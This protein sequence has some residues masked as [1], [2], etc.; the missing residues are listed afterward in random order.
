MS[1]S[2]NNKE[3]TMENLDTR[4][5]QYLAGVKKTIEECG[6]MGTMPSPKTPA[7]INV[8][9]GSAEELSGMLK[10]L[11]GLAGV[12][13]V[14][15]EHMPMDNPE[16]PTKV[17]SAPPMK[18]EPSHGDDMKR[19]LSMMDTEHDIEEDSMNP[20]NE[21]V[22]DNSPEEEGKAKGN[23]AN[24]EGDVDNNF[25][26]AL[27]GKDK[28]HK[29]A[30]ES[31]F[32]EYKEFVAESK[33]SKG[34]KCNECGNWMSECSCD[35]V[36][37]SKKSKC[38]CKEK[39]K[40]KCP[41]HGKM[42][43][44]LLPQQRAIQAELDKKYGGGVVRTGTGRA[45]KQGRIGAKIAQDI[46]G[47]DRDR[48][49]RTGQGEPSFNHRITRGSRN[50]EESM[51]EVG[52][53]TLPAPAVAEGKKKPSAGMSKKAKSKLVK[54]AKKGGDIGK[55]GKNFEKVAKKAG[56]GEKGKRIAAAAMWKNAAK[57]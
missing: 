12:H 20:G 46:I 31:L 48:P 32:A 45:E 43:E 22:Y 3:S 1:D 57:K 11:M 53:N 18:A 54:K 4:S 25:S 51:N 42:D 36:K 50:R 30:Y 33:K 16:S 27:V 2:K 40:K 24:G 15:P 28:H 7:T 6:M 34:K 26:N 52:Y 39:G 9:A 10:D 49:N 38:C 55:K 8:T 35:E 17:I 14:E 13:K 41:V 56:G 23:W 21:R 37:E 29:E 47:A 5:L 44:N 19:L